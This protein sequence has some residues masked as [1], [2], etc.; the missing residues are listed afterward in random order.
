MRDYTNIAVFARNWPK[1]LKEAAALTGQDRDSRRTYQSKQ[2]WVSAAAALSAVGPR[3]I[4]FAEIEGGPE[5]THI[6]ELVEVL[7]DPTPRNRATI[8]L[9]ADRGLTKGESLWGKT[10]YSVRRCRKLDKPFSM[11]KLQL[12]N[13]ERRRL[14]RDY[15][16]SYALVKESSPTT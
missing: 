13:D 14:S 9:L 6:A 16:Y 1:Y 2:R 4:Y 15:R 11:S 3:V 10:L 8:R 5:I 7:V 12:A